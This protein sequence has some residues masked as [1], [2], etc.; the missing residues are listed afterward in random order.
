MWRTSEPETPE[1][2]WMTLKKEKEIVIA[3]IG[4]GAYRYNHKVNKYS[5]LNYETWAWS[6]D[7]TWQLS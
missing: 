2:C 5:S 7:G 3:K 1:P 4:T 6:H